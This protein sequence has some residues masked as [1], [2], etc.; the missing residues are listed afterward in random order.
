MKTME[1]AGAAVARQDAYTV[2]GIGRTL[3]SLFRSLDLP[4]S[5]EK[6]VV[7][8]KPNCTGCFEPKAGRTTHPNVVEALAQLLLENGVR[9]VIGE[10][11]TVGTDS[12]EAFRVTGIRSVA[13]RLSLDLIDFK[14]SVYTDL[15]L[16]DGLILRS[17]Q[18]PQ[19][20][21]AVDCVISLAKLKTNFVSGISCAIKNLKGLLRDEDKLRF[22][23]EGLAECV[24][25]LYMV[26][27]SKIRTI[28][29]V[30]GILGSELYEPREAGMMVVSSDLLMCDKACAQLM[31]LDP[32]EI[33]HLALAE[34]SAAR[35][36]WGP[37][38]EILFLDDVPRDLSFRSAPRGVQSLQD[39][40]GVEVIGAPPCSSCT[41]ALHHSLARIRANRPDL[42]EGVT[43]AFHPY[44]GTGRPN[45]VRF[46]TCANEEGNLW[47]VAGCPPVSADLVT[48]L[49]K[50]RKWPGGSAD[51]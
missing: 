19:E 44:S 15:P 28:G 18:I 11:P 24:A 8:I 34:Q 12:E 26:I 36:G 31:G 14:K 17:L 20:I 2:E 5:L 23:R 21:L 43:L 39:M 30:D 50:L 49:E 7:L 29:V 46:G 38:R 1:T 45:A 42:L 27:S 41:G 10:S 16:D 33:R 6:K 51:P 37:E 22:H 35:K 4:E 25:D 13:D 3:E 48:V 9:V 47:N 32:A 40:F